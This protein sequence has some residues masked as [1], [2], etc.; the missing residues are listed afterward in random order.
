MKTYH[1]TK[2]ATTKGI[3]TVEAVPREVINGLNE[4]TGVFFVE[5]QG[6]YFYAGTDCFESLDEARLDCIKRAKRKIK[7][8]VKAELK[9]VEKIAAWESELPQ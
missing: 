1:I 9:L 4:Q 8:I 2:Y 6:K 3:R 7:S 5:S